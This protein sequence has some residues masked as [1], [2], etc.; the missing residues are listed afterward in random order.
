MPQGLFNLSIR[1][2][3]S[4]G[5]LAGRLSEFAGD[6]RS[7]KDPLDQAVREVIIPRIGDNLQQGGWGWQPMHP[8]TPTFPYRR[9]RGAGSAPLL[10]VTGRMQRAATALARWRFD[11]Q[12]GSAWIPYTAFESS[13]APYALFQHEGAYTPALGGHLI[14][15]RPFLE[16]TTGT[17]MDLIERIYSEWYGGRI[18]S[19]IQDDR[20][21]QLHGTRNR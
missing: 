11:G 14:P 2:S 18:M 20:S 1:S 5:H 13:E 15:S 16:I 4:I 10:L 8:D 9:N 17:D 6:I 12:A 19:A 7:T 3:P 21:T